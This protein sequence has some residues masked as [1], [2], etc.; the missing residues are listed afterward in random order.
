MEVA[1]TF[2]VG[3]PADANEQLQDELT[4]ARVG[5]LYASAGRAAMVG[6][7]GALCF[8]LGFYLYAPAG[9]ILVW[10]LLVHGAQLGDAMLAFAFRRADFSNLPGETW[11]SRQRLALFLTGSAWGLAP[12]LFFPVGDLTATTVMVLGLLAVAVVGLTAVV[13]DRA[14]ACL[15]LLSI[16]GR[17]K[18]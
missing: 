2:T 10:A 3:S 8:W 7:V 12:V 16:V 15:W 1:P 5:R 9:S 17:L 14:G 11:L 13:A 6:F 4:R 18:A